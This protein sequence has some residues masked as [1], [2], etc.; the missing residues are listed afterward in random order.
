MPEP[1]SRPI[2]AITTALED[3]KLSLR[4]TYVQAVLAAGGHPILAA[5]IPGT[6]A[7]LLSRIDGVILSGGDDPDM[8]D[9]GHPTHPAAKVIHPDRQAF[10]LELL[11]C[12][13]EDR[14]LPVLGI[15]LGMQLMG[16]HGGGTLDQHLPDNL[17]TH[18][19]HWDGARHR[20]EGPFGHG[21]VSSHHRQALVDPGRFDIVARAHDGVIEAIADPHHVHRIGVQWHPE[22]TDEPNMGPLV[23]ERFLDACR[24]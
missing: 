4:E 7:A 23:F 10:E 24:D 15:C 12:L 13:E 3:G 14:R 1:V 21:E 6:A 22:R 8:A 5:P 19:D 9:F 18:A 16:L 17:P 20:V 11:S 2:I